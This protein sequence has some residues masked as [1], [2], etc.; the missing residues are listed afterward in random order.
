[1]PQFRAVRAG[2]TEQLLNMTNPRRLEEFKSLMTSSTSLDAAERATQAASVQL[3]VRSLNERTAAAVREQRLDVRRLQRQQ[4]CSPCTS[5][6]CPSSTTAR[7]QLWQE[8]KRSCGCQ[9]HVWCL[10]LRLRFY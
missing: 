7:K 4:I 9:Q 8:G 2:Q 10:C 6:S 3:N 5:L 1:M